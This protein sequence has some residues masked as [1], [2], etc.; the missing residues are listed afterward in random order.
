MIP[1]NSI[2][3]QSQLFVIM[4]KKFPVPSEDILQRFTEIF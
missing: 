2:T 1:F 3:I 4:T